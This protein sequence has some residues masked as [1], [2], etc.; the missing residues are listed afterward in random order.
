MGF[1]DK[2]YVQ[3]Y[4][5]NGK[6]KTSAALGVALRAAGA[7]YRVLI[8]QFMKKFPYSET[9]ALENFSEK[10]KIEQYIGDV[11]VIKREKP[12]DEEL[13]EAKTAIERVKSA[14]A[15]NEFDVI[16][17]DEICVSIYFGLYTTDEIAKIIE[18]KPDGKEL[19]LTGRYCPDE[20][21]S[22]AD[23]VTEMK[24]IKHYYEQ[25]VLSRKGIDS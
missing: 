14:L 4:T 17:M 7:G 1:L 24:E 2:G 11:F 20:I 18:T 3:V 21:I 25:G 10:I 23:L 5:G 19:I 12:S 6:G 16:I 13:A 15:E 8:V 9:K 22:A